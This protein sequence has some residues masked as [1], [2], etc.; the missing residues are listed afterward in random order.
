[1]MDNSNLKKSSSFLE[2]K[3]FYA[4]SI[5]A[6]IK[7]LLGFYTEPMYPEKGC[8]EIVGKLAAMLDASRVEIKLN[9]KVNSLEVDRCSK[10]AIL[11]TDNSNIV[12]SK[13]I[14]TSHASLTAVYENGASPLDLN[15]QRD[16]YTLIHLLVRDP[17]PLMFS[18]VRF[19]DNEMLVRMSDLTKYARL[20]V[21]SGDLNIICVHIQRGHKYPD[22]LDAILWFL[23]TN[24]Y[25]GREACIVDYK[26][27]YYSD[28]CLTGETME[29][30]DKRYAPIIESLRTDDNL[31]YAISKNLKRWSKHLLVGGSAVGAEPTML[32]GAR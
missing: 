27:N 26:V 28:S 24:D 11:H 16:E 12:T 10:T 8:S 23:K 20:D 25:I 1:M 15:Y 5:I 32:A 2:L 13:V 6:I 21:P 17:Q 4:R 31:S 14:A 3:N 9:T 7:H 22:D 30:M 29:A 18:Y 19:Y